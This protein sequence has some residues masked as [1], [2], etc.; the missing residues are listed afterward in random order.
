M[1]NKFDPSKYIDQDN[2]EAK[3]ETTN[4]NETQEQQVQNNNEVKEENTTEH[5]I[6]V[7]GP[8]AEIVAKALIE[9]YK[10][11]KV[12][13]DEI[14]EKYTIKGNDIPEDKTIFATTPKHVN[15]EPLVQ[16]ESIKQR[17]Y[18]IVFLDASNYIFK[19]KEDEWFLTNTKDN[20]CYT[21]S[22]LLSKV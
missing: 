13:Y 7:Y 17:D 15:N 21:F 19:T 6:E 10:K 1:D 5:T 8:I 4:S 2:T 18:D 9:K 20:K 14:D 12:D 3:K 11:A 22:S 16:Y